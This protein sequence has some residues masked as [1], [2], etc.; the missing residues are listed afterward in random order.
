MLNTIYG[1][2]QKRSWS[3]LVCSTG[4]QTHG[5]VDSKAPFSL[6]PCPLSLLVYCTRMQYIKSIRFWGTLPVGK[7]TSGRTPHCGGPFATY[8]CFISQIKTSVFH[9][10][11]NMQQNWSTFSS[12]RC[13]LSTHFTVLLKKTVLAVAFETESSKISKVRDRN[14]VYKAEMFQK[15]VFILFYSLCVRMSS[16]PLLLH[17][18]QDHS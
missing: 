10:S 3:S 8:K 14:K 13:I 15:E 9:S 11:L 18:C 4:S 5:A 6:S 7:W 16:V 17:R 12:G 2:S 1:L